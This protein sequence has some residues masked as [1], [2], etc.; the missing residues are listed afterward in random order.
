MT[1][2]KIGKIDSDHKFRK[3]DDVRKILEINRVG[4]FTKQMVR[5]Q[6]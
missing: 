5:S 1:M 6:G 3:T 4:Q 2:T